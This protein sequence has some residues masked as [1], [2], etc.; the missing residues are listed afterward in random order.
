MSND[1]TDRSDPEQ[2]RRKARLLQA[3][4]VIVEPGDANDVA[5]GPARSA[6]IR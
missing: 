3:L 5:A 6:S 1:T 4:P 2:R